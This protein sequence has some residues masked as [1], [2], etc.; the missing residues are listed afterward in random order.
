MSQHEAN[1]ESK[2]DDIRVLLRSIDQRLKD[3]ND[4]LVHVEQLRLKR[5]KA[6][7]LEG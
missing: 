6:E 5:E 7:L 2:L 1:V 3:Q 4:F